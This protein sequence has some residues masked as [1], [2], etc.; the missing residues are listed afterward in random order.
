M[1]EIDDRGFDAFLSS[2]SVPVLL[3]F[4]KPDCGGC[5]GLFNTLDSFEREQSAQVKILT[6]NVEENFQI[7]AE[8]EIHSLPALALFRNGEFNQ[9][10]G[11][12]VTQASL[13]KVLEE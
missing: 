9:F 7:P 12:I 5:R 10:I 4:W 11:G 3:L 13:V 6:M 1:E 2:A 8:L